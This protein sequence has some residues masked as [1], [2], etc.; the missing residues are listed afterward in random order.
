[1]APGF[2]FTSSH[3]PTIAAILPIQTSP[4][5]RHCEAREEA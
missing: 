3:T 4:S 5:R 1:M 2:N